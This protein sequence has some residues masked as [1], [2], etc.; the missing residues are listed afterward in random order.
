MDL[1]NIVGLS[2]LPAFIYY[3]SMIIAAVFFAGWFLNGKLRHMCEDNQKGLED[4]MEQLKARV[5]TLE[6]DTIKT[7]VYQEGMSNVCKLIS[8]VRHDIRENFNSLS[9]RIDTLLLN[10]QKAV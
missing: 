10:N 7:A 9:G 8:E 6:K 2:G 5:D 3:S 4:A 1:S